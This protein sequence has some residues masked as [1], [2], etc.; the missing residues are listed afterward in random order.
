MAK[1]A[2]KKVPDYRL[3]PIQ[4]SGESL[5]SIESLSAK[6]KVYPAYFRRNLPGALSACYLREGAANR[7]T[8]AA[9]Y[10]PD[11]HFLLVLDGWRPYEVQLALYQEIEGYIRKRGDFSEKELQDQ[12]Q[13][14][15]A[16]PSN[17][18]EQPSPH[19]TGG[20]VDLTIATKDGWLDM[21]TKFDEISE[22]SRTDW[23]EKQHSLT[24]SET[25]IKNN[26]RL[27]VSIMQK[28]GFLNYEEEW[29]HFDYGN[30]RWSLSTDQP[31]IY[32]GKLRLPNR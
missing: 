2:C 16:I 20:A 24:R 15:V 25:V 9:E 7:L 27:L 17:N 28:A 1:A 29:W 21:G 4:E 19:L 3:L 32:G 14:F 12:V 30:Q 10:L 23:Y 6:V 22:R 13:K 5:V 8:Q 18:T 11:N 31:A 26:R